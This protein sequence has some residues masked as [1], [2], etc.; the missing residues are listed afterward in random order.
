MDPFLGEVRIFTWNW[1]P[2]GWA[3]CNGALL[4]IAQN[5]ALNALLGPTY[6]GDSTTTFGLPDLRGRTPIHLGTGPDGNSYG[7]GRAGGVEAVTLNTSTV[8]QHVHQVNALSGTKGNAPNANS[9]VPSTVGVGTGGA[10]IPIYCPPG[11]GS[12]VALASDTFSTEGGSG[13]H[14]NMQPFAVTN[15][16][17]ATLGLFPP[18]Q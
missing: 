13:P 3:L 14:N 7:I 18:R 9:A 15:F 1:A 16:C 10:A 2:Y 5:A 12:L 6:G 11:Y 4:P 17:I 8:P